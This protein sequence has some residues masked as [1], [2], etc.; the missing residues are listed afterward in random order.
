MTSVG[1]SYEEYG[2]VYKWSEHTEL[3]TEWLLETNDQMKAEIHSLR[4]NLNHI[5][6]ELDSEKSLRT[7]ADQQLRHALSLLRESV[8]PVSQ[9]WS[10]LEGYAAH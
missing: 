10:C 8:R 6:S 1:S 7:M 5:S 3:D 2:A 4:M 9:V